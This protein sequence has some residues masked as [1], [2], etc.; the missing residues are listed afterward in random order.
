MSE[1]VLGDNGEIHNLCGE[2]REISDRGKH[3]RKRL[4]RAGVTVPQR[5]SSALGSFQAFHKTL[6]RPRPSHP[7]DKR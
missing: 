3:H 7:W 2:E 1:T 6:S 4:R 5:F